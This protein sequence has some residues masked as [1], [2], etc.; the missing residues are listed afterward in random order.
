MRGRGE[1][2]GREGGQKMKEW[3][4]LRGKREGR[5]G[6]KWEGRDGRVE[7]RGKGGKGGVT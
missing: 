2:K 7:G 4:R 1:R 6:R 5:D 3:E